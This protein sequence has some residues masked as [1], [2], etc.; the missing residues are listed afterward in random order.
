MSKPLENAQ[1]IWKQE[2]MAFDDYAEFV[3]RFVCPG[4]GP[5][6]LHISADSNCNVYVGGEL[7][8]FK[9]FT[10]YPHHKLYDSVDISRFC[11]EENE[12]RTAVWYYGRDNASYYGASPGLIFEIWQGE[13][14]V[15]SSGEHI[16][17]RTDTRYRVGYG[18]NITH[19]LGFSF[20]FDN[21]EE[22]TLPW[23]SS[24]A[25]DKA[26]PRRRNPLLPLR[27]G[28]PVAM[29]ILRQEEHCALIDLG[30]EEVGFLALDVES[31]ARQTVTIAYGEHICDGGVRRHIGGRDFSVEVGLRA[32]EN[33]YQNTFRR[34]AGRYLE[35]FYDKP[36]E[37]RYLGLRP[38]E[39]PVAER[40][41]VADSPLQQEIYDTCVRTLRLCMHEHY[42]DCPW[43][44]QALYVLDSRNQMLCGYHCFDNDDY[45]RENLLLMAGG[46]KEDGLLELTYPARN[47]PAIP[48]FSLMYPVAVREYVDYTGDGS[49]LKEVMPVIES[50]MEAFRG[51]IAGNGM[52]ANLPY[53]YWNFYE[54]SEGSHHEGEIARGPEAPHEEQFDLI[55]NC[56]YLLAEESYGYLTGKATDASP[57]K[58]T[59]HDAFYDKAAGLYCAGTAQRGLYTELGNSLAI[60]AGV[61]T[62]DVKEEVA[63][64]LCGENAMVPATLSMRGFKYDALLA[65]DGDY[66]AFVLEDIERI[67]GRMLALGATSF[68]ETEKGEADFDGAGSL[69]HGWSAIPVYYF[70]R[71]RQS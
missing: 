39:H 47:T 52:I 53:P 43:R 35:I 41:F 19:Q 11:R 17:S 33:A 2:A 65:A 50:I 9:Q 62:G 24:A 23:R 7:V 69:C 67:Y 28:E 30:R 27:L 32:G 55:L 51:R 25:V 40:P 4:E 63:G 66:A 10:D 38:V 29:R 8:F 21:A 12:L 58:K 34:L 13:Q 61:A 3:G 49:I 1:W 48:F 18:K 44:E 16:K 15:L 26:V 71:L 14:V 31:S 59:I 22:N 56:G 5:V 64:H 70:H 54:W 37:L 60:L 6:Y 46:L 45:A 57:M 42:E 68:W 20:F 36:I